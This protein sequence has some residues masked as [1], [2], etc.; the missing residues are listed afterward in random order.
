MD[1]ISCCK[2]IRALSLPKDQASAG[3]F[4]WL[5]SEEHL[6]DLGVDLGAAAAWVVHD[7]LTPEADAGP[8]D[9]QW[10]LNSNTG[11]DINVLTAWQDYTGA[12]V[13]VGVVDTGVQINHSE[14]A[15][16]YNTSID[17]DYL[18]NSGDGGPKLSS[19]NHGTAVAGNIAAANDGVGS[20]GV[21]YGSTITSF[22]LIGGGGISNV[23]IAGALTQ[24]VDVSNNSWGWTQ[25]L[26]GSQFFNDAIDD[27]FQQ[28]ASQNRGGLGTALVFSAGNSRTDG[29]NTNYSEM[30][31]SRFTITVAAG[32]ENG[33][34]ASFSNPGASVLVTAP[35]SWVY[36]TDRT[37][38]DGYNGTNYTTIN[39]TSFSAPI[40]S[41]VVALMLDANA[42]LGYRDIQE[43]LAYSSVKT[44]P[45]NA[46]WEFNGAKNWNGGGLHFSEDFGAGY[47]DATAAVRLAETWFAID[48]TAGTYANEDML[49][50]TSANLNATIDN[51]T[52]TNVINVGSSFNIDHVELQLNLTHNRISDLEISLISP[53]GTSSLIFD[54]PPAAY[55]ATTSFDSW[56]TFMSTQHWGET[57]Q[58]NW[59]LSVKDTVAGTAA[60]LTNWTLRFYGDTASANNTYIYTNE[61]SGFTGA[62]N[63]ARRLLTDA[64]GTDTINASAAT[65]DA[66]INLNAGS[67]GTIAGN[68]FSIAA[69]TVIENAIGGDGNDTITGNDAANTLI[70]GRGNDI[71]DGGFG[72]DRLIGGKGDDIYYVDDLLDV[73]IENLNEGNDIIYSYLDDYVLSANVEQL[74]MIGGTTVT[75]TNGVDN[76][77]GNAGSNTINGLNGNDT[78]TGLA[79]N[80]TLNGDGGN[81]LLYGGANNDTLNGGAGNDTLDGGDGNDRY[82]YA[83][84]WGV[85]TITDSAGTDTLD[86][87]G[88]LN[89]SITAVLNS[90]LGNEVAYG[91]NTIN[92]NNSVIEN[93]IG[94]T[95]TDTVTGS[96]G[97]NNI[98]GGAGNDT[99]RG[100]GGNDTIL[101]GAG[102]DTLYG[103]A[104]ND[105]LDGG[106]LSDN[107]YGGDGN[108]TLLGQDGFDV[109]DGGNNDDTLTG[110]AGNDTLAGG[111]GNDTYIFEDGWGTD[112]ITEAGGTGDVLDLSTTTAAMT[113]NF[114]ANSG[115]LTAGV[116]S[117]AWNGR[118]ETV[119]AGTANDVFTGGTGSETMN[120]GA[121]NDT[122]RITNVWG[123]D[124]IVDSAGTELLDFST[125]TNASLAIRL[126]SSVGNEASYGTYTL[127]WDN[128]AI[129]NVI[130]GNFHDNIIGSSVA[131]NIE[132][133]NGDDIISGGDGDDIL[134]GGSG[135]DTISGD[136]G[137]DI[138]DGGAWS[139]TLN[140]GDGTD[141]ITGG[142]GYD[143]IHGNN[144]N[145]NIDGGTDNDMLYGDAG[146]DLING[147]AGVDKLYGGT[148]NDTLN[149]GDDADEL[150][151]EAGDD[152][153]DG[154]NAS[155]GM[156]GGD[157]ND[158]LL[159]GQ[160]WDTLIGG[161]GNDV[162]N[163]GIGWDTL[164]GGDGNDT[165]IFADAWE[166]DT[167]TDAAGTD[168]LNFNAV[169]ANLTINMQNRAASAGSNSVVWTQ[170][171][172]ESVMGGEGNDIINGS[173]ADDT[174]NG[175][176]GNDTLRGG[177]GND[178]YQFERG[179]GTDLINDT[180]GATD[181]LRLISFNSTAV[182]D[183]Q[184]VDSDGDTWLDRLVMD[185][186]AGGMISIDN[187]FSDTTTSA[188]TSLAGAGL[189]ED[190]VF[191]GDNVTYNFD[192][193]QALIA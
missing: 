18:S 9:G 114:L 135:Y 6:V 49:T 33:T 44:D 39:G 172:I 81:D 109:L 102:A 36:T 59:T 48:D 138:I 95:G 66:T 156:N 166:Q 25:A 144:G 165:Y 115:G 47:V 14:F 192:D 163:G 92:W 112:T 90:S 69:G 99:L 45:G 136:A 180:A 93:Y 107:L 178:T 73:V 4:D 119:M 98:D 189:M 170:A 89:A 83:N 43:I 12:G 162:L 124:N 17:W 142:Q 94:G 24:N 134:S 149:G 155:D 42:N 80:D 26:T 2:G 35:G 41:G 116:N 82:A 123:Q 86:L 53:N 117:V 125:V 128:D 157:G 167:L 184:A 154:G 79:G 187:Y 176:L 147:G 159:G 74:Q 152:T 174:M 23:Q 58:G 137:N 153:L 62:A 188:L 122:Y 181:S 175:H 61:Y 13:T 84:V 161:L 133:R 111:S 88:V 191:T 54:N 179:F 5:A 105:S 150:Y 169:T 68:A 148:E 38:A 190:I 63:A 171:V 29:D 100:S 139:D 70:G 77:L 118:V 34:I 50:F 37:G 20:T 132:G 57:G 97:D 87:S 60:T 104:G 15:G 27:A 21:A 177:A 67:A 160:G 110:G 11:F 55:S 78:L 52:Y 193:V 143:T 56:R 129:E 103:D 183:W 31:N 75:G 121:G 3:E 96:V 85:D 16:R 19:D 65:G 91:T 28:A 130:S 146:N 32:N 140:G 173:T 185:F 131:N 71:L 126:A 141:T 182:V 127:N 108:D 106:V 10:H 158:M 76:I 64:S 101:G 186:G 168:T 120:G 22:R 113:I 46:T 1:A 7:F 30:T 40:T 151:G 164:N 51:T 72:I 145:D 8:T